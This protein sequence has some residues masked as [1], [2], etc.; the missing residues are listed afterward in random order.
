MRFLLSITFFFLLTA[1]AASQDRSI[2]LKHDAA[3]MA[4]IQNSELVAFVGLSDHD[5]NQLTLIDTGLES[6]VAEKTLPNSLEIID[7][8]SDSKGHLYILG[9]DKK[10]A[11]TVVVRFSADTNSFRTIRTFGTEFVGGVSGDGGLLLASRESRTIGQLDAF[12]FEKVED[13]GSIWV[14]IRLVSRGLAAPASDVLFPTKEFGLAFVAHDAPSFLTVWDTDNWTT[15][16]FIGAPVFSLGKQKI[17]IGGQDDLVSGGKAAI[18]FSDRNNLLLFGDSSRGKLVLLQ[19]D[20]LFGNVDEIDSV[21]LGFSNL[22]FE[23]EERAFISATPDLGVIVAGRSSDPQLRI[24]GMGTFVKDRGRLSLGAPVADIEFASDGK[25]AIVLM[26]DMREVRIV[27]T[28]TF[29][30]IPDRI[31]VD[32]ETLLAQSILAEL[33]YPVGAVDGISGKRTTVA[34]MLFRESEQLPIG[35]DRVVSDDLEHLLIAREMAEGLRSMR[36]ITSEEVTIPNFC[37]RSDPGCQNSAEPLIVN[38]RNSQ[39]VIC[40][41]E[42]G[43]PHPIRVDHFLVQTDRSLLPNTKYQ[44]S[45]YL[46]CGMARFLL[47]EG[48]F[49]ACRR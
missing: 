6:V 43:A 30:E 32:K 35:T 17:V 47:P 44:C 20:S 23:Q 27:P 26:A 34:L 39:L 41:A 21:S 25:K 45:A 31:G 38:D 11:E 3:K 22:P 46:S 4:K 15:I 16:N 2:L 49:L 13:G 12:A 42:I 36:K 29:I 33:D 18:H 24:F 10:S 1:I 8:F 19:I 37:E 5:R 7:V 14:E 48:H 40:A 9:S 28:S